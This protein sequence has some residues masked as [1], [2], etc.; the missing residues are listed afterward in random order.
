[1][2]MTIEQTVAAV[3][4]APG[5]MYTREDVISLLGRIEAPKSSSLEQHQI[6]Q[7]CEL[8]CSQIKDNVEN[9]DTQD[10]CDT[11]SAEFELNGN[12]ISLS[13]ISI[14]TRGIRDV[15][16]D[17]I[18]D[19]IEEFFEELENEEEEEQETLEVPEC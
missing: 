11:D 10:V 3:Q 15:V 14:Y 8:I 4:N 16:V 1:M 17:G 18:G 19:V 9:L 6:H 7:L 13:S 5:S 2:K 12:E